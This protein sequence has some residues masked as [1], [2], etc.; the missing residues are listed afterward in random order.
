M[1]KSWL[2]VAL[3]NAVKKTLCFARGI[4]ACGAN[5]YVSPGASIR[6]GRRI[7][8]GDNVV[9][10]PRAALSVENDIAFITIGRDSYLS[11]GCILK[12]H[13]GSIK[14]GANCTVNEHAI[15]YGK[16]GLEI[17]NGVRIA[18]QV[19]LIPE[20]HNFADAERPI[21]EQGITAKGIKI[22]DDVWL[23]AGVKVLDGVKIGRGSV[24]GAGAVVVGDIP[25][26]SVAVGIPARV[27]K[28]RK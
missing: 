11:S 15:L 24:I 9:I 14:L 21:H 23:G 27:I 16:G 25:E 28:K 2:Y 19:M 10:E 1:K 20:N 18:A 6:R 12:T 7:T 26:Y 13:G 17:G 8:L 22:A 3:R 4:T 5:V